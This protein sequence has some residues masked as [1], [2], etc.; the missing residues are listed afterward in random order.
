MFRM[1]EIEKYPWTDREE[2]EKREAELIRKFKASMNTLCIF[3]EEEQLSIDKKYEE[4]IRA[5]MS[6][7]CFSSN[8]VYKQIQIIKE[9]YKMIYNECMLELD[10]TT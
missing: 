3:N 9:R 2:A 7:H 1:I 4:Y 6:T 8:E 10:F 5:C